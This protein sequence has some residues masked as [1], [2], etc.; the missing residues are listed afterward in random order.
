MRP[1]QCRFRSKHLG[2]D[3]IQHLP[4]PVV[5]GISCRACKMKIT[6]LLP[7]KG[8]NDLPLI[9][10]HYPVKRFHRTFNFLLCILCRL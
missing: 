4:A 10:I 2:V 5:I 9:M 7:L 1:H 8:F 3:K 6:Y